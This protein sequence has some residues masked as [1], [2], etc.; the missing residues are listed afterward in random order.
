MVEIRPATALDVIALAP[1]L[2]PADLREIAAGSGANPSAALQ[3]GVEHSTV[4]WTAEVDGVPASMF[5]VG[6]LG[7]GV[8]CPWLL[9]SDLID[10]NPRAFVRHA[11][12]YIRRMLDLYPTLRNFV[13]A[14]NHR[15]VRWLTRAGFQILPAVPH[16][17]AGALFHPFE[18][19]SPHV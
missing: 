18:M 9:G 15:A 13:H 16:G 14:E 10:R 2:R 7:E 11:R 12:H 17:R 3:R 8:G 1:R 19:R 4:C 6:S 5:G